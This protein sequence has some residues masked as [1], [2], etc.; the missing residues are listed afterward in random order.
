MDTLD[1][2][3]IIFIIAHKYFRGYDSYVEYYVNNIRKFYENS[4][5]IIV[6]NNSTYKDDIFDKLKIYDNVVLLDNNIDSKF[7]I[8]AYTVGLNYIIENEIN[9]YDYVVLTQDNYVLKNKVDFNSLHSNGTMVCPLV[10]CRQDLHSPYNV[11]YNDFRDIWEP[12]L[13]K[14]NLLDNLDKISFCWC[15]SFVISTSIIN[16]LYEYFN[17]IFV[18]TRLESCAGERYMA[19]IFYELN[20]GVNDT[21]DGDM[22]DIKYDCH[23]VNIYSDVNT[24]FV[25]KSQGRT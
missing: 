14:F 20:G 15:S 19:R 16:K 22:R 10:G 6:D 2:N 5:I 23:S 4:L 21:I 8:G 11:G 3:R 13:T 17:Q 24:F 18:N 9:D 7:E 12:I 25:K 1:R